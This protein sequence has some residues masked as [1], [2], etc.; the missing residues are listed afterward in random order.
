M[1]RRLLF[2]LTKKDFI[3]QTFRA[4]GKGGQ[5]QNKVESGVRFIHPESG[6]VGESREHRTQGQNQKAAFHRLLET[7]KF[8]L[9]HKIKCSEMMGAEPIEKIVERLMAPENI[10]IETIDENGDWIAI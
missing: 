10:K 1:E 3:R 5:N 7:K 2:S 8:K 4:G 6:A 9:W